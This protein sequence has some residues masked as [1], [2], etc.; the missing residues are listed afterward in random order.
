MALN[1]YQAIGAASVF[2]ILYIMF[3]PVLFYSINVHRIIS[4]LFFSWICLVSIMRK[5]ER[6]SIV[7]FMLLT[8]FTF[9]YGRFFVGIIDN[10]L[11]GFELGFGHF[12]SPSSY[13]IN[14]S[15][16]LFNTGL[17]FLWC[18]LMLFINKN[19]AIAIKK[20]KVANIASIMLLS[21][22]IV[23]MPMDI[24][25]KFKAVSIYGYDG[26][27]LSQVKYKFDVFRIIS[28]CLPVSLG[29]SIVSKNN[30]LIFIS[31]LLI[32]VDNTILLLLGAREP[33]VTWLF[34]LIWVSDH[35]FQKKISNLRVILLFLFM[36]VIAILIKSY[37]G[38]YRTNSIFIADFFYQQ[39]F[40]SVVAIPAWFIEGYSKFSYITMLLPVGGIL[41]M[42]KIIGST[43]DLNIFNYFAYNLNP[44][45]FQQGH[46][47]GWSVFLDLFHL[48][49]KNIIIYSILS[50]FLGSG[51]S[52]FSNKASIN[53][54][55]FI[56]FVALIP[57]I[58]YLPRS[59]LFIF[60]NNIIYY[61]IAA[62][63]VIFL[64]I[65]F[66]KSIKG[67]KNV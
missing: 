57:K 37:R 9:I 12:Y 32:M 6:T 40:T 47:L 45:Y 66:S 29:M 64:S 35:C 49:G 34:C 10:N 21:V 20:I 36:L 53:S 19:N 60:T 41:H 3:F 2:Y 30:K 65:V 8:I 44:D 52:Y 25:A 15:F 62:F 17:F 56:I 16:F 33:F 51:I 54:L 48:S 46:G 11:S 13:Q 67:V 24:Y 43:L 31:I 61:S 5:L 42:F 27:Y 50:L 22:V 39:G 55:V 59:G 58:I 28:I 26:L 14:E 18:G 7:H 1:K 63:F 38:G 23:L 4:V